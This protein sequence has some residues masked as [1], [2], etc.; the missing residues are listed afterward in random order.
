MENL[1]P[2]T[3]ISEIGGLN[4]GSEEGGN[5]ESAGNGDE[6]AD[7]VVNMANGSSSTAVEDKENDEN[8]NSLGM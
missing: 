5:Q 3:K 4:R 7:D 1:P 2:L 6:N 8:E